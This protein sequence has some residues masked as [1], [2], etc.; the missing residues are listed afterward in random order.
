MESEAAAREEH[1]QGEGSRPQ[2]GR[3]R[4]SVGT[5]KMVFRRLFQLKS[6]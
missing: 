3:A 4:D 6:V 5:N 1:D 2:L